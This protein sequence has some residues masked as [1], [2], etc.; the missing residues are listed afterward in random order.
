MKHE[1]K[2]MKAK[3][4]LMHKSGSIS[5]K[6]RDRLHKKADVEI[7][8]AKAAKTPTVEQDDDADPAETPSKRKAAAKD[9]EPMDEDEEEL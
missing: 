9:L 1:P 2:T 6:E 5:D 7:A 4:D 8:K 3:A